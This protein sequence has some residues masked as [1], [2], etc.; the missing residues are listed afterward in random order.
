MKG[1]DGVLAVETVAHGLGDG[2]GGEAAAA[3]LF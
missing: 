3:C 1:A 2:D